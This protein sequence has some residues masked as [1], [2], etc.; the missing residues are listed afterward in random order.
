MTL[1]FVMSDQIDAT[2]AVLARIRFALIDVSFAVRAS[3]TET[4]RARRC[5]VGSQTEATILTRFV[6]LAE[7]FVAESSLVARSAGACEIVAGCSV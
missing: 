6:L 1:A 5:V 7:W 2:T 4:A 3:V